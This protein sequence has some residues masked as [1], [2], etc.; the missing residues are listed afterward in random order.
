VGVLLPALVPVVAVA[1][2]VLFAGD[3]G[4][5]LRFSLAES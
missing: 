3:V 5:R 1:L 4:V 2:Y